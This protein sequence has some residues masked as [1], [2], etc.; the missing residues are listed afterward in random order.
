MP[1]LPA[2]KAILPFLTQIVG[3]ALPVFTRKAETVDDITRT[4]IAELQNAVFRD[5]ESLKQLASRLQQTISDIDAA[6]ARIEREIKTIRMLAILA[7]ILSAA[8]IV[9]WL[10]A[11]T[12]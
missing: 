4:Q 12:H 7:L 2:A 1:W 3:T 9:L 5:A 11:R 6:S 10:Y 8:A